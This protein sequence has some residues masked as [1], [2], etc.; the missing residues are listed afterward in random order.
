[1]RVAPFPANAVSSLQARDAHARSRSTRRRSLVGKRV[2]WL[3][4]TLF[5]SIFPYYA[6]KNARNTRAADERA[7]AHYVHANL[8]PSGGAGPAGPPAAILPPADGAR[9]AAAAAAGAV[10][11]AAAIPTVLSELS[12][13]YAQLLTA[14]VAT[15]ELVNEKRLLNEVLKS[16]QRKLAGPASA[17][18]ASLLPLPGDNSQKRKD[19]AALGGR[20]FK[21]LRAKGAS[22]VACDPR[23]A[24]SPLVAAKA[25]RPQKAKSAMQ[26]LQRQSNAAIVREQEESKRSAKAASAAEAAAAH[27]AEYRMWKCPLCR[28]SML[29]VNKVMHTEARCAELCEVG[30]QRWA[31]AT[32]AASQAQ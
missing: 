6:L 7:A 28:N 18:L 21:K 14:G 13:L 1:V 11:Q 9:A 23:P 19:P 24:P 16:F 10:R 5:D 3:I 27:A 29:E 26:T 17:L 4:Y 30:K 20:C 25:P 22:P 12:A 15:S 8:L 32:C 31:G 2:D